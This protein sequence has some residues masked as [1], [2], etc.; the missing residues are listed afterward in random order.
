MDALMLVLLDSRAPT[1]GHVHSGGLEPAVAAGYISDLADL[2]AFCVG[3]LRTSGRVN[4][5]FAAA[6]ANLWR[7]GGVAADWLELD[8]EL[9]ARVPSPASRQASRQLGRGTLRL[10]RSLFPETDVTS[11]WTACE[12]N[13]PHHALALGVGVALA[14]G[15]SVA[16]AEAAAL[17]VCT[18]PA[19]AAVRLL[20]LDPFAT[21]TLLARLAPEVRSIA[22]AAHEAVGA[23][24]PL[25]AD[26]S[27]AID[28]LADY[29]LTTEVR[30]FAS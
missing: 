8:L 25:P 12:D 6:A 19:S 23:R 28:L 5:A 1:G 2:E 4:A 10:L 26:G 22:L 15:T 24:R 13:S 18:T 29:H 3:K 30:L 27:P 9:E 11:A 16:A 14:G 21:H 20:G 17:A 7:S